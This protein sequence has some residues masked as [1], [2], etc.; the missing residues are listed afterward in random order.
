MLTRWHYAVYVLGAFLIFTGVRTA[1]A[2]PEA[3]TE[4]RVLPFLQRH[5]RLTPNLHGHRFFVVEAGRRV[6]TPLMLAL[7]AIEV[8]DLLFAVDS[9]PA[10]FAIS[11]EP[12]IV[13]SSN[14][15]AILGLRA[16]YLVLADLL[17]D[18]KYLHYGLAAILVFA[19]AKMLTSDIVHVPHAVSLLSV[20]AILVAAIIPSV[21]ARRRARQ[22]SDHDLGGLSKG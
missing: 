14:V 7:V 13:Y 18:L 5:L 21:V 12:F 2:A 8:T 15:F 3:A 9:V 6:A 20:V 11:Q 22:A 1:R 4:G 17:K 19:G 16:L 10:V